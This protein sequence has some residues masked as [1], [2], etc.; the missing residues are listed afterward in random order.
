MTKELGCTV[1][2]APATLTK[3]LSLCSR[4]GLKI[5][6]ETLG[7]VFDGLRNGSGVVE[8]PA[9]PKSRMGSSEADDVA[10]QKLAALKRDG[11]KQVTFKDFRPLM[12]ITGRSRGWVYA[13]LDARV[14]DG[15]LTKD[16]SGE[17]H[18]YAFAY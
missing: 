13:W 11:S 12:E 5:A 15:T 16:T 8:L 1:C 14:K 3:T 9:A 7:F 17:V 18:T 4:C 10:H 6:E 2:G